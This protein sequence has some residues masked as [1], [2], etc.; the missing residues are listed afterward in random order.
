MMGE[1]P[2]KLYHINLPILRRCGHQPSF[3]LRELE[4]LLASVA[5]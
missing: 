1:D 3:S 2:I 5:R 4:L